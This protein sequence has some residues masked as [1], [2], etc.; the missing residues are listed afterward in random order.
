MMLEAASY[1]RLHTPRE[2]QSY[3]GGWIVVP[4]KDAMP[5]M[6]THDGSNTMWYATVVL[7]PTSDLAVLVVSN[8]GAPGGPPAVTEARKAIVA[9]ELAR[10]GDAVTSASP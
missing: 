10:R 6:L 2:G 4:A 3:A 7:M 1:E 9:A 5:A 8:S